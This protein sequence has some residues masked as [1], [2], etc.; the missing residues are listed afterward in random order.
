MSAPV[1]IIKRPLLLINL[2]VIFICMVSVNLYYRSLQFPRI[3]NVEG[4]IEGRISDIEIKNGKKT[5]SVKK[6]KYEIPDEIAEFITDN[7]MFN[8]FTVICTLKEDS[9]NLQI[10]Q[11]IRLEGKFGFYD[12]QTNYGQFDTRKYYFS[13]GV[14]LKGYSC[15]LL[16]VEG[17]GNSLSE[18]L[19]KIRSK[20]LLLTE[21]TFFENDVGMMKA[22]LLADRSDLDADVKEM[23]QKA[24]VSHILAISGLHISLF[25]AGILLVLG[26]LPIGKRTGYIICITILSLYGLM[27]GFSPSAMRAIIM[28]AIMCFGKLKRRSYD[29]VTAM[30]VAAVIT[31]FAHPFSCMQTGYLLSYL[32]ILGLSCIVPAFESLSK[33]NKKIVSSLESSASVSVFTLP[34]IMNTYFQYPLYSIF[35]NLIV[36]PGMT[37]VLALGITAM[38][39]EALFPRI[40]NIFSYVIHLIFIFYEWLIRLSLMIPCSVYRTGERSAMKCIIYLYLVIIICEIS[41]KIRNEIYRRK[42]VLINKKR[43]KSDTEINKPLKKLRHVENMRCMMT[44]MLISFDIAFLLYKKDTNRI[45]FL[46]VGQGLCVVMEISGQTY[47]YDGGSTDKNQVWTYVIKPYLMSKG[48]NDIDMWFVSHTDEDHSNG[49]KEALSDTDISVKRL[50]LSTVNGTKETEIRE[51]ALNNGTKVYSARKGQVIKGKNAEFVILSPVK[52]GYPQADS[53]ENSLVVL[54]RTDAGNILLS[55]DAGDIAD[56]SILD[57]KD[58]ITIYQTEHHG[59][60]IDCNSKE[61]LEGLQPSL[62]VISCGFEN[63]YGHPHKETLE[64]FKVYAPG[65]RLVRTDE[66]GQISVELKKGRM[67][68][69]TFRDRL[70][71]PLK[72]EESRAHGKDME[73]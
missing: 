30:S 24:G 22:I 50:C 20:F 5:V 45:D 57:M 36:I 68:V 49:I 9:E 27:I 1:K 16:N 25:G 69:K 19:R 18:G 38:V 65:T 32:A 46:D 14:I 48:I 17:K 4:I 34:V 70:K 54:V 61:L 31:L 56:D 43:K 58:K 62:G 40:I 35:L 3:K 37:F 67:F 41:K 51:L 28:F 59:S 8:K 29:P 26:Y 72:T 73:Y 10:G 47:C 23:Y 53:N 6:V 39:W 44:L 64:R 21:E 7:P 66:S 12:T 60:S 13:K 71:I 2:V 42:K 11:R 55:G 33:R 15:R 52:E 63:S